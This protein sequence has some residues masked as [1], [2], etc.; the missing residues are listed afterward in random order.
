[1][2][3]Q[4]GKPEGV[5]IGDVNIEVG[6][7]GIEVKNNKLSKKEDEFLEKTVGNIENEAIGMKLN[8]IVDVGWYY[9]EIEKFLEAPDMEGYYEH[10]YNDPDGLLTI[11]IGTAFQVKKNGHPVWISK[12]KVNMLFAPLNDRENNFLFRYW[13]KSNNN[14][15]NNNNN[16]TN[17]NNE[18]KKAYEEEKNKFKTFTLDFL[19]DAKNSKDLKQEKYRITK[20]QAVL[21]MYR[22]L[23]DTEKIAIG[24]LKNAKDSK[25]NQNKK[26]NKDIKY[27]KEMF[28]L[29]SMIYNMGPNIP[30]TRQYIAKGNRV[31]AWFEIRYRSNKEHYGGHYKRRFRESNIFQLFDNLYFDNKNPLFKRENQDNKSKQNL[32]TNTNININIDDM[33]NKVNI[34][35]SKVKYDKAKKRW[36]IGDKRNEDILRNSLDPDKGK[37][38]SSDEAK[39]ILKFF[40]SLI[41]VKEEKV[42]NGKKLV[43]VE[44]VEVGKI[45]QDYEEIFSKM[46]IDEK[47]NHRVTEASLKIEEIVAF[48]YLK[49][50]TNYV[51]NIEPGQKK[52]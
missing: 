51:L 43:K 36:T 32:N 26:K 21:L 41:E 29:H 45:M 7:G 27:S 12:E 30:S 35:I 8:E 40:N 11:G 25:I 24:I 13:I 1:M 16:N 47:N 52:C 44:K 23:Y 3:K 38:V 4:A 42:V 2:G 46:K 50:G 33:S 9:D 20:L 19:K 28:A 15:N 14:N 17:N 37:K 22:E 49:T 48:V 31:G 18:I 5:K 39:F 34:A 6:A 10:L